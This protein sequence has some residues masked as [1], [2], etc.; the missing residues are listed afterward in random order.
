MANA[1]AKNVNFVQL[2]DPDGIKAMRV[3]T[4]KNPTAA[5]VFYLF[6]QHMD[7][8]NCLIVS[9]ET[10]GSKLSMSRATVYRAVR[11]LKQN[12]YIA[13]LKSGATN[14][15][16]LNA[17]IVWRDRGDKK[18]EALLY[19]AVLLSLDEQEPV[20]IKN[21]RQMSIPMPDQS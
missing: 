10:I 16:T 8:S 11:Y 4:R 3:L 19:G 20:V 18:M 1:L 2:S 13:I 5:S 6:M 9:M 14:V 12:N 15:Y 7:K 17:N 21:S